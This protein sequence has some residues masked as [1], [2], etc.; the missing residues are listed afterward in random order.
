MDLNYVKRF[1]AYVSTF[2]YNEY[3]TLATYYQNV[4][5]GY[6]DNVT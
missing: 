1:S 2:Y 4:S 6:I 3:I 5:R